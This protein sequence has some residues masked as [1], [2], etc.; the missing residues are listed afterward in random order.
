[1]IATEQLRIFAPPGR[2]KQKAVDT[3]ISLL[4]DVIEDSA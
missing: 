4:L 1:M 2:R 3:P